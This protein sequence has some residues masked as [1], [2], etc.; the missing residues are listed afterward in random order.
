M[1]TVAFLKW[2]C[3]HFHTLYV[4]GG[5]LYCFPKAQLKVVPLPV[6]YCLHI[7]WPYF[8]DYNLNMWCHDKQNLNSHVC[9]AV[10]VEH[11]IMSATTNSNAYW[12]FLF[13]SNKVWYTS[14]LMV[15]WQR[16]T[17][18]G[19]RWGT[20]VS[21][22]H[23]AYISWYMTGINTETSAHAVTWSESGPHAL[24]SVFEHCKDSVWYARTLSLSSSSQT[25]LLCI[26]MAGRPCM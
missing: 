8:H 10:F 20:D 14:V 4:L 18:H 1:T 5:Y 9:Y 23:T 21:L 15:R 26:I 7:I 12:N 17:Y 22:E 3:N 16:R 11:K 6:C 24:A 2:S 13:I 25:P 19:G